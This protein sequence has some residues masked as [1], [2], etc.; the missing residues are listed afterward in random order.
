MNTSNESIIYE[1]SVMSKKE[2]QHKFN[3]KIL[4][5]LMFFMFFYRFY[6]MHIDPKGIVISAIDNTLADLGFFGENE[7]VPP[8]NEDKTQLDNLYLDSTYD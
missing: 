2:E 4:I 6:S 8:Q 1:E 5:R 3:Q 7:D